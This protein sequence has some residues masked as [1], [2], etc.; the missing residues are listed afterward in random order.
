MFFIL[1]YGKTKKMQANHPVWDN[2][3]TLPQTCHLDVFQYISNQNARK[4]GKHSIWEN[5][6]LPNFG[7]RKDINR[8]VYY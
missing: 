4:Y 3:T 7:K 5:K 2:G 8:K 6:T 1:L